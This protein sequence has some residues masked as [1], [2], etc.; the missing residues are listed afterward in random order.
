MMR[1]PVRFRSRDIELES[2]S[3]FESGPNETE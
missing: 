3:D 1:F 2:K